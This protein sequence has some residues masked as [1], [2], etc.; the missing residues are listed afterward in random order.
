MTFWFGFE[1]TSIPVAVIPEQ[2]AQYGVYAV[3]STVIV[4][5]EAGAWVCVV[6][7]AVFVTGA[8]VDVF[9]ADVGASFATVAAFA[10][11]TENC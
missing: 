3:A 10:P 6:D 9:G 1:R 5:P 8:D 4:L 11:F 7:D 2:P